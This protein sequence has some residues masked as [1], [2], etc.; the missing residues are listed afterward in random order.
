MDGIFSASLKLR[1]LT[2]AE[3]C[4]HQN[5]LR[6]SPHTTSHCDVCKQITI[7]AWLSTTYFVLGFLSKYGIALENATYL[8]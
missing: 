8:L 3:A 2:Q 1:A 7:G 4:Y 6:H 5:T